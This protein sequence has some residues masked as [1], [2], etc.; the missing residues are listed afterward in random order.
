MKIDIKVFP[1]AKKNMVRREQDRYKIYLTAPAVD[2]KANKA[3]ISFLADYFKVRR[4]EINII[5]G[6]KSR[7]KTINITALQT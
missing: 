5:K 1:G 2:G 4:S 6:L 3:L 7:E